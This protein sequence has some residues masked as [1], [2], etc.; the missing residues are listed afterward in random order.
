M[1]EHERKYLVL[2]KNTDID[3][4]NTETLIFNIA[5]CCCNKIQ[6]DQSVT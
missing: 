2:T 4:A 1:K 3:E 6:V 5:P